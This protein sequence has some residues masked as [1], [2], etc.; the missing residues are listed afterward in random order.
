MCL[1]ASQGGGIQ[2]FYKVVA[3]F[4]NTNHYHEGDTYL[5]GPTAYHG[6]V[7]TFSV[8]ELALYEI[9]CIMDH[10]ADCGWNSNVAITID[11]KAKDEDGLWWHGLWY[12]KGID[13]GKA[14]EKSTI[15]IL[16]PGE[17]VLKLWMD[18]DNDGP[19]NV[20]FQKY[21]IIEILPL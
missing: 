17:H 12:N 13:V 19:S 16:R 20:Y 15:S 4:Q 2:R 11:E 3:S 18:A 21:E 7:G 1:L 8:P 14:I 9:K 10:N 5:E 6:I